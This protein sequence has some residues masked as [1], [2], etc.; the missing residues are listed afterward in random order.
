MAHANSQEAVITVLDWVAAAGAR[1][2]GC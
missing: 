2:P 1:I